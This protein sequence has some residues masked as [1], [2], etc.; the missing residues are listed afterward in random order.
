MERQLFAQGDAFK[1]TLDTS[2]NLRV[3][4]SFACLRQQVLFA[5]AR[6]AWIGI[7]AEKKTEVFTDHNLYDVVVVEQLNQRLVVFVYQA[8][9]E[10]KSV[11]TT[12]PIKRSGLV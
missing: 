3:Y 2:T 4:K 1:S 10:T 6:Q 12:A 11:C 7:S 8:E 5:P 9:I